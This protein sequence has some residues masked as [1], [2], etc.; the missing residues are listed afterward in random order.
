MATIRKEQAEFSRSAAAVDHRLEG[1][2]E[3]VLLQAAHD[4]GG[5]PGIAGAFTAAL[6]GGLVDHHVAGGLLPG[7]G[8]RLLGAGDGHGGVGGMRRGD[9]RADREQRPDG[10]ALGLDHALARRS[11]E[12]L[13][14]EGQVLAAA[15]V[16]H[17]AELGAGVARHGVTRTGHA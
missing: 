10:A 2:L 13:G 8:Q 3:A 9:D 11:E 6:L 14:G 12:A 17:D 15:V 1:Q 7:L 5:V 16:E 4:L